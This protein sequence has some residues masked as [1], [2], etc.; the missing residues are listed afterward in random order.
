GRISFFLIRSQ[1]TRVISSPSSSTTGFPTLIFAMKF[2][3]CSKPERT[4]REARGLLAIEPHRV[5][6]RFG[7]RSKEALTRADASTGSRS[8]LRPVTGHARSRRPCHHSVRAAIGREYRRLRPGYGEFRASRS[9]IGQAPRRLAKS[10]S[11]SH[12]RRGG[13]AHRRSP[14]PWQCGL[15]HRPLAAGFRGHRERPRHGETGAY[16]NRSGA[17]LARGSL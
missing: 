1:M 11:R 5:K 14:N 8:E 3:L 13:A 2:V 12:G 10:E 9:E 6:A 4:Q 16:A 15:R 7:H 17:A